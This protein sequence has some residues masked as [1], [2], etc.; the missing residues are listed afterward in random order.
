MSQNRTPTNIAELL[1][2]GTHV[3]QGIKKHG[4][5]L[6]L[7]QYTDANFSPLVAGL[8]TMQ[9]AFNASRSAVATAYEPFEAAMAALRTACLTGRK[10]LSISLGDDYSQA[11]VAPGW[12]DNTTQVPQE[13]AALLALSASLQN[14]LAANP[15]FEVTTSKVTFTSGNFKALLLNE[16]AAHDGADGVMAMREA[17]NTAGEARTDG[18]KA[19]G[20]AIRGTIEFLSKK[21]SPTDPMWEQFGLNRPGASNLPGKATLQDAV[22]VSTGKVLATANTE[23]GVTYYRWKLKLVG[24]DQSFRFMGRTTEPMKQFTGL[25]ATGTVQVECEWANEAGHGKTSEPLSVTLS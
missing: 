25:P 16:A 7:L 10:I 6:G 18:A 21:L 22:V 1:D 23:P 11:W 3:G 5:A 12:T 9:D 15:E 2:L 13:Q 17:M 24:V 19:L 14:F 20:D 8:Q 4:A